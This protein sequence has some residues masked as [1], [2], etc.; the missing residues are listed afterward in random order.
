MKVVLD[1]SNF[2]VVTDW[3]RA[4]HPQF[5]T[6]DDEQA[7]AELKKPIKMTFDPLEVERME[8]IEGYNEFITR[9]LIA[10]VDPRPGRLDGAGA[11]GVQRADERFVTLYV[12]P[13]SGDAKGY[14]Y[15]D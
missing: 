15:L 3:L 5:I 4:D 2:K 14:L 8:G 7:S 10:I 12:V 11:R 9:G 13:E 6:I 1:Q